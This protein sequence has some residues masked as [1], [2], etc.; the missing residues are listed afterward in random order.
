LAMFRGAIGEFYWGRCPRDRGICA[1]T[2]GVFGPLL[3]H[4]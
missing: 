2:I 1:L 3:E 4:D